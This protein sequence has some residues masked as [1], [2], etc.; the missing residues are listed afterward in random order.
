M[1]N[2]YHSTAHRESRSNPKTIDVVK[3]LRESAIETLYARG[4]LDESQKRTADKFRRLWESCGG[5]IGAMDYGR[6][7]VDGGGLTEPLTERQANAGRELASCRRLLGKRMFGLVCRVCGQGLS[8]TE[9]SPDGR[10]KKTAADN[11]RDSLDD[12]GE[13]WGIIRPPSHSRH[14]LVR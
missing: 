9:L 3:N 13:M 5:T 4:K 6:E 7:P 11:L 2:P 14:Q 1:D 10:D 8:L 12:L